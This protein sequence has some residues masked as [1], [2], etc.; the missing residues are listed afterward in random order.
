MLAEWLPLPLS[1]VSA[2]DLP[3][4]VGETGRLCNLIDTSTWASEAESAI[5]G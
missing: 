3:V 4:A 2:V 5:F 1:H